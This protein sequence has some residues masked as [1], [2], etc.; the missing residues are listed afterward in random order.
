VIR[1]LLLVMVPLFAAAQS[2]SDAVK[3]GEQIFNKTCS[4]GYC[5]GSKGAAGGA[6]RLVARGLTRE[7]INA[8]VTRGVTGTAMPA[9]ESTLSR[10]DL[11]AVVVYVASINGVSGAGPVSS[12]PKHPLSPEAARGQA[13]FYDSVRSF[14]RCATCHEVNGVGI[15]VAAPIAKV[16]SD[17]Q[18]LRTLQ[19]PRAATATIAGESMPALVVSRA[20]QRTIFYD[21]T[22]APPVARTVESSA[23]EV[24]DGSSWKHSA[25]IGA[26]NDAE[27]ASILAWLRAVAAP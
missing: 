26:Y 27:L 23:V 19:T 17:A 25:F 9:F 10:T 8:R 4:T 16:P 2:Q 15:S 13:L 21:L 6:P 5:H 14:A 24:K 20:K 1:A 22:S 12:A 3:Q 7:F 18:A 11:T